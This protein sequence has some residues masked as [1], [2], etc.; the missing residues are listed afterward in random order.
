M[1]VYQFSQEEKELQ[2]KFRE[3]LVEFLDELLDNYFPVETELIFIRMLIKQVPVENLIGRFIR[4][5]LPLKEFVVQRDDSFFLNNTILYTN[6]KIP[7]EKEE[8]FKNLWKSDTLDKDDRET[9]WEWMMVFINI[10]EVYDEKFG[11][12]NGWHVL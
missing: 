6:G 8:H 1:E 2:I 4:D 10:A 3:Q 7:L 5:L 12:V 9:I 11:K